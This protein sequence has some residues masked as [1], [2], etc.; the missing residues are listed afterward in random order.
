MPKIPSDPPKNNLSRRTLT[1]D[2]DHYQHMLDA[3]DL[4][5]ETQREMIEALWVLVVSFID[6][7][8]TVDAKKSCGKAAI[9]VSDAPSSASTVLHSSHPNATPSFTRS[10]TTLA[11]PCQKKE[12]L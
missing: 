11:V 7:G 5:E 6:L 4:E 1:L 9:A 3:P 8:Y 10:A 12:P 2:V